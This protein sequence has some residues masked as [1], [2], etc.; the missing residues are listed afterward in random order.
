MRITLTARKT[1]GL[2]GWNSN[3]ERTGN[4]NHR[5]LRQA[6]VLHTFVWD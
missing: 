2:K 6:A 3:T 1:V 4:L 5:N